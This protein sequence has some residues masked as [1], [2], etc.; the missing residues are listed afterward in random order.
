MTTTVGGCD[1]G[2]DPALITT[3]E[4]FGGALTEL[5][6][7]AGLSIRAVAKLAEI[8]VS[9]LSGY[10]SGRHLPSVDEA[11]NI[12]KVLKACGVTDPAVIGQWQEALTRVRR[13]P[14]RRPTGGPGPYRGLAYYQS[15]DAD[16][17]FGRQKL[18]DALVEMAVERHH[19][20]GLIVVVG[21]SGSG[22]SSLLRAGLI[23]ELGRGK[24][25]APGADGWPCLLLTPGQQPLREL[26]SRL[27]AM[28]ET[29]PQVIYEALRA[30]PVCCS[31]LARQVCG[32]NGDRESPARE[33]AGHRLVL[34]V[35]QFE[36]VFAPGVDAAER[37]AFI[38]ALAAAGNQTH[39]SSTDGTRPPAALVV[40][41]M[42]AD[43]YSHAA[44]FPVLRTALQDGQLIVGPMNENELR[45]AITQPARR[46]RIEIEEGLV[47]LL[48]RDL[49]PAASQ[50]PHNSAG[51]EDNWAHEAGVLPFLSHALLAT[52][53]VSNRNGRMTVADYNKVGGIHGA[54]KQTADEVYQ[55]LTVAHRETARLLF[56]RLV[57]VATD[58]LDTLRRVERAELVDGNHGARSNEFIA[59]LDQFVNRRLI[60]VD[61]DRV[62]ITHHALLIAWPR[63][64]GWLD[65][66]RVG[67]A[68]HRQLNE[69]ART[70]REANRDPADLYRGGRLAIAREW[71]DDPGHQD[72]LTEFER[73]YLKA[74]IDAEHRRVRRRYQVL[75]VMAVLVLLAGTLAGYALLQRSM[76]LEQRDLATSR[77]VA[78]DAARLRD[79]DPALAAQLSL[80]AYKLAPTAEARSSLLDTYSGPSVTRVLAPTGFPQTVAF[81]PDSSLMA[82]GGADSADTA[83]RVWSLADRL[84]PRLVSGPLDGHTGPVYGLTFSPDGRILVSSGA[85]QTIRVWDL[86]DPTAPRPHGGPVSDSP[87]TVFAVAFSPDGRILAAGGADDTVRL[88]D[89]TTPHQ[90]RPL[91][92][93]LTGPAGNVQTVAFNLTGGVLAAGSADG[94]LRLWSLTDPASPTVLG[95]PLADLG[96]VL[97]VA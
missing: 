65:S 43:F 60:T 76:A 35:D 5:K 72:D 68:T 26:T 86:S 79:S 28:T 32:L 13:A 49:Q 90:L 89:I 18:T 45:E 24:V 40:L 33:D 71:A 77:K 57:H 39:A 47:E 34:V 6:V 69:A 70:W 84:H 44:R 36:E 53:E 66:D 58:T 92:E 27:A 75:V 91:G 97:H 11:D 37:A 73:D 94:T 59:V 67:L 78:A 30:D 52:W 25:N 87:D 63:L 7:C 22:K 95:A 81:S 9:T 15:E 74:S 55:Q 82:T 85:D 14:G 2:I 19:R 51:G 46:A 50:S 93:P 21:P 62:E 88:Y 29:A 3:R 64:R 1:G 41:G 8:P 4:G 80:I 96:A 42:R 48:L 54:I 20:G 38:A 17:F 10:Y 83:I 61:R 12:T 56:L 16:W 31:D 23:A